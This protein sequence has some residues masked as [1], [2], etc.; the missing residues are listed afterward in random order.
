M[1]TLMSD[2]QAC[3]LEGSASSP[4]NMLA[5]SGLELPGESTL[6]PP[7]ALFP[8]I[9]LVRWELAGFCPLVGA[10]LHHTSP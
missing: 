5:L 4:K 8:G 2:W 6:G 9:L 10:F 7:L 3:I 1:R